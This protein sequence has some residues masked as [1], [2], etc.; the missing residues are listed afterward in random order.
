MNVKKSLGSRIRGWLP[1]E[2]YLPSTQKTEMVEVNQKTKKPTKTGLAVFGIAIFA[3]VVSALTVLQVLGLESNAPYAAGAVAALA[4]AVLS[5]LLWKPRNQ[6][7]RPSEMK[8]RSMMEGERKASKIIGVANTIMFSIFLGTY[9]LI[10]PN[11]KS[12]EVTLGLWIILSLSVILVNTLLVRYYKK[13]TRPDGG[14]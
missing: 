5:V 8:N 1:K 12:S 9:F 3:V 10:D 13:Q 7:S 4:G 11:I 2:P 6:I 14:M